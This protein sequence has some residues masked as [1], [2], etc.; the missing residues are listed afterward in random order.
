ME[1]VILALIF[2]GVAIFGA[3]ETARHRHKLAS[4]QKRRKTDYVA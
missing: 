1:T 3:W 2:L 4:Q